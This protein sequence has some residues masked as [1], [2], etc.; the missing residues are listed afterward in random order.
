[1][2]ESPSYIIDGFAKM[3]EFY[4]KR[5]RQYN[6]EIFM[7]EEMVKKLR[8]RALALLMLMNEYRKETVNI[9]KYNMIICKLCCEEVS[10]CILE[11]CKH[12]VCCKECLHK[13]TDRICP[14][15]REP[16]IEFFKLYF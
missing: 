4:N 15:C 13:L 9:E 3:L 2:A 8:A 5:V 11:P 10:D 14:V 12:C 16:I 7:M 1:M 6:I